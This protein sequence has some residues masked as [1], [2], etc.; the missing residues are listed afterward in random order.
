MARPNTKE[1][2]AYQ[3][4]R[5]LINSD[6]LQ[7]GDLLPT[8]SH[9]SEQLGIN[10]MTIAKALSSLK[11]E[12]YVERRAGRGTTLIR[13]PAASSSKLIVVIA[14]W[15][16][17]DPKDDWYFQ[18]LVY[19]IQSEAIR[20]GMATLHVAFHY[21][22]ANE[23]DFVR[24]RDL[25]QAVECTGAIVIDPFMSTHDRLQK[26]LD[27]LGCPAVWAGSSLHTYENAHRVDIDNYQ[28]A[29][30][31][32]EKLIADGAQQIIFMSGALNTTA[33][34][35]RFEGYQGALEKHG[36]TFD[37]GFTIC[38]STPTYMNEAGSECAGIYA[39]RKLDA[40]ALFLSDFPMM[41][42]IQEFCTRYPNPELENLKALP[43]A[44]FDFDGGNAE[45]NIRYSANQP[46]EEIGFEAVRIFMQAKQEAPST[47]VV[48]TLAADIRT[49]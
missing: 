45:A 7:P 32:T 14:P 11:N 29:F 10:R 4:A 41:E 9:I 16:S 33:R 43:I 30:N 17:N 39:A 37:E 12:G 13:K 28:T 15:P 44:T 20:N 42:G 38:H 18:R 40:D 23:Q 36:I 21:D 27:D 24:I 35:R 1:E 48:K 5:K 49:L 47:P 34:K 19:S 6:E 25:Y 26:F 2:I 22:E 31:L 46:I 3:Y 8:E